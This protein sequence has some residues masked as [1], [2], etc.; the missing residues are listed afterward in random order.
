MGIDLGLTSYMTHIGFW[1]MIKVNKYDN[2]T[3][4]GTMVKSEKTF[5]G[6]RYHTF[7]CG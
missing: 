6:V 2:I 4:E 5:K 7:F 3:K 1:D